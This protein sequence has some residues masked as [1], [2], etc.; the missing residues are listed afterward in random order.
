MLKS[1]IPPTEKPSRAAYYA[2]YYR[3]HRDYLNAYATLYYQSHRDAMQEK[4][5]AALAAEVRRER[6]ELADE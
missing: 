6:K 1:D 5:N 4:I 2:E 3:K